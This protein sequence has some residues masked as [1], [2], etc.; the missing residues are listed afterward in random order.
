MFTPERLSAFFQQYPATAYLLAFSGGLDS[1]VLLHAAM[2]LCQTM[3]QLRLRAVHVDHGLQRV[4]AHWVGHCRRICE[5]YNIPF[6]CERLK[7]VPLAGDSVE[8]V[9]RTARYAAFTRHLRSGEMLLTAHHRNDQ[10]ETLLLHLVRGSGVDGLAAMPEV[11]AFGLGKLGR[12][13]LG[14][15]RQEL[16][17]YADAHQLDYITDP[18]NLENR[19]DRNYL[20]QRVMPVLES[21]W[22]SVADTLS[23]AARLQQ[24][25][26]QLLQGFLHEKL[27]SV[28]GSKPGTLSVNLLRTHELVMQKALLREWLA[29][30]GFVRPDEARLLQVTRDVLHARDDAEP[31]IRWEGC[32]IRRYRDEVYALQPLPAHDTSTV[33]VWADAV[34]LQVADMTLY[35]SMLGGWQERCWQVA[36]EMVSVR[37]RQ[38]GETM[39][40]PRRGGHH[41]LKNL[42]QEAGVPP[43]QRNRLP[44]I[45]VGE[46][47]VCIAG[48]LRVD[49]DG[50]IQLL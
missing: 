26:R 28:Q 48:V 31:C 11:R 33:Q 27:S 20:R 29:Q 40:I 37:F 32:E 34:P 47:L 36:A 35:P 39:L 3:P 22:P 14:F 49:P 23:R 18:S 45:Y 50:S 17:Q 9:A 43:W 41:S 38:G 21:R 16:Q 12:P 46:R 24:E 7:V 2:Q 1:L 30:A 5:Q 4:S 6:T 42:L 15:T 10:A 19:F 25:S 13:L 44:L 8:A